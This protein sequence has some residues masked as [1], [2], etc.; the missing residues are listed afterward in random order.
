MLAAFNPSISLVMTAL[1]RPM[2]SLAELGLG[3]DT[4]GNLGN[5]GLGRNFAG[6]GNTHRPFHFLLSAAM[7][8]PASRMATA[9][10]A[11]AR[12]PAESTIDL[13]VL[14]LAP[15]HFR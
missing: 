1:L 4:G 2:A 3:H 9:A 13:R 6:C 5:V 10:N 15:S 7:P 11:A 12:T 14:M 8:V